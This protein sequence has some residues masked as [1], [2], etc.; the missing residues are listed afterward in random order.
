MFNMNSFILY[1]T[2]PKSCFEEKAYPL[3]KSSGTEPYSF[4]KR[5]V[6]N[7]LSYFTLKLR[8]AYNF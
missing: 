2:K 5:K 8:Y 6:K 4:S 7:K 1:L 3:I